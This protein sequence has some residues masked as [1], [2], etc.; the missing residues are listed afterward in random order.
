MIIV[1]ILDTSISMSRPLNGNPTE[2]N[3]L[4]C[5][6]AGVEHF[7]KLRKRT[8]GDNNEKYMLATYDPVDPIKSNFKDSAQ[9]LLDELRNVQVDPSHKYNDAEALKT[10]FEYLNIYRVFCGFD[11]PAQLQEQGLNSIG[12]ELY[13]EPY[14]WDHRMY[15]F[16][17]TSQTSSQT[18][19]V[20]QS[21]PLSEIMGG[22]TYQVQFTHLLQSYMGSMMGIPPPPNTILPLAIPPLAHIHGVLVNFEELCGMKSPQ[23]SGSFSTLTK[24]F[25]NLVE[26]SEA[27]PHRA[28]HKLIYVNPN[29]RHPGFFPIPE[30]SWFDGKTQNLI[31]CSLPKPVRVAH[32]TIYIKMKDER[33][34][35]PPGVPFDKYVIEHSDFT[36]ELLKRPKGVCWETYVQNSFRE[37]GYGFPF[38]FLMSNSNGTNVNLYILPYNYK[39][40]FTLLEKLQQFTTRAPNQRWM[41][42]F[43]KFLD[44]TP[45][46]YGGPYAYPSSFSPQGL[47]NY[48]KTIGQHTLIPGEFGTIST[49]IQKQL[50]RL[51]AVGKIE[52]DKILSRKAKTSINRLPRNAFDVPRHA[53]ADTLAALKQQFFKD[54]E[55]VV[56]EFLDT[57][58][59]ESV[60]IDV[61]LE[62]PLNNNLKRTLEEN[63]PSESNKRQRLD[64]QSNKSGENP[65]APLAEHDNSLNDTSTSADTPSSMASLSEKDE[66]TSS[67]NPKGKETEY[68]YLSPK[69]AE[70]GQYLEVGSGT[71]SSAISSRQSTPISNISTPPPSQPASV[72]P[73]T[74][75]KPIVK[76][77]SSTPTPAPPSSSG[78]KATKV[79]KESVAEVKTFLMKQIRMD[80][81]RYDENLVLNKL[82]SIQK[83]D[84]FT[85]DQ[86][87]SLI[88]TF[89]TVAKGLRR[90][91]VVEKL[92]KMKQELNIK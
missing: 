33:Y 41:K 34:T 17:I 21:C 87:K 52:F 10:V 71:V 57:N 91:I 8:G 40:L 23:C 92:E 30:S 81:K 50:H 89:L 32:P 20:E 53:L 70:T 88:N 27:L 79:K 13:C 63:N 60:K 49:V 84:W 90:K 56:T 46:Y 18:S 77:K 68:K 36:K 29:N 74:S 9:I 4:D 59:D 35:I 45:I 39:V 51:K 31:K 69:T 7:F 83:A 66:P 67:T 22:A 14:R 11:A 16:L 25:L 54:E 47:R 62:A 78:A 43:T 48:L 26:P 28:D 82:A 75:S 76:P 73:S 85:K 80:P 19:E 12:S 86:K 61:P 72:K 2:G 64:I 3:Y 44:Y 5:A 65:S 42:D 6:K 1:F 37:E 58:D 24:P 38:G 55:G 15:T